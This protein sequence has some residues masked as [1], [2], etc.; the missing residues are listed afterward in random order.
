[1]R[2]EGHSDVPRVDAADLEQQQQPVHVPAHAA[3]DRVRHLEALRTFAALR[4]APD[5]VDRL[6]GELG[7]IGVVALGPVFARARRV[8][9]RVAQQHHVERLQRVLALAE[10]VA[11]RLFKQL[12]RQEHAVLA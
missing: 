9:A 2:R 4:L 5:D 1:M 7:A 10:V 8:E 11:A 12:G 6:V 3:A